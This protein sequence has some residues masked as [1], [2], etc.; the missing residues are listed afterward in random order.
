MLFPVKWGLALETA[1]ALSIPRFST[2]P[3]LS[4]ASENRPPLQSGARGEA[5][6]IVQE[7]L[8]DLG[9]KMPNSTGQGQRL[10]DGIFGNETKATVETFQRLNGLLVDGIVG[11]QTLQKLEQLTIAASAVEETS[12]RSQPNRVAVT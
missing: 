1:M 7:A 3:V 6:A 8:I 2:T 4:A 11:R 10:P 9:F 5:V 12:F